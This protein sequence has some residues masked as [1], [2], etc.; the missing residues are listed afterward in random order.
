MGIYLNSLAAYTLYKNESKKHILST[1]K[2]FGGIVSA[3]GGR[4]SL[5]LHYKAAQ[6]W[7]DGD[8]ESYCILFFKRV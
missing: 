7:K 2:H 1:N 6:I 5:Y 8:G 4:E 3:C